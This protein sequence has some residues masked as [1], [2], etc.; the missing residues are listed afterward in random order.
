MASAIGQ[1]L[2][3]F[4]GKNYV[5]K[6]II[7]LM[8]PHIHYV[9]PFFGGGAVLLARDPANPR[10]WATPH[11]GVSE[12]VNDID[13][14]LTNF[15]RVL[16]DET[17]F[18]RFARQVEAIPLS[19]VEWDAA[20]AHRYG[21]DP[22]ADAVAFFVNARQSRAG[23]GK[24]FTSLTRRRL[25]RGMNGN[26]SEWLGAVDGLR[27]VHNRLRPVVIKNLDA[28]E[29]IPREDTLGTLFYCDPPYPHETRTTKDGYR[30][31]MTNADHVRLA[32][33]LNKIKGKAIVSSYP[34]ELYDRLYSGW[35]RLDF[36]KANDAAGGKVKRREIEVL[37][38]NYDPDPAVVDEL[39]QEE[40]FRRVRGRG[41]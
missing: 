6:H 22:V 39:V 31:E 8:H 4:G 1:P 19:S 32:G 9:E 14:I 41:Q 25:R 26:V 16:Q 35:C 37:L 11:K 36:E 17:L 33:V 24:G 2:K 20:H 18:A 28:I 7:A 29:L 21:S 5:A 38:M 15:W 30:F 34:S 12:M 27:D 3:F 10:L 13:G 23:G 40:R